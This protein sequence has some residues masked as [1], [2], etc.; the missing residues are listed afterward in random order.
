VEASVQD[1]QK[2]GVTGTPAY[3]LGNTQPGGSEVKAVKFLVGALPVNTFKEHID[4]LLD[5]KK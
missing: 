5:A 1:G 2:V 4:K 3:L